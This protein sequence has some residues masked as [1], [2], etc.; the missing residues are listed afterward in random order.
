[1]LM[2]ALLVL[3]G[4]TIPFLALMLAFAFCFTFPERIDLPFPVDLVGATPNF[5][6]E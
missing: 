2:S 1:M 6:E 4:R 3:L 5:Q